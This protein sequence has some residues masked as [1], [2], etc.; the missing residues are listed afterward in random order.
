M[1]ICIE[2]WTKRF[3]W[4]VPYTKEYETKI[5]LLN[6]TDVSSFTYSRLEKFIKFIKREH[7]FF[8]LRSL[9]IINK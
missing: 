4:N 2:I 9:C 6:V 7:V 5:S 8:F 3:K 1:S